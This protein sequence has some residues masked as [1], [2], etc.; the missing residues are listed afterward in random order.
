MVGKK[1]ENLGFSLLEVVVAAAII[2]V[3]LGA[4]I[5]AFSNSLSLEQ[6]NLRQTQAV[7]LAEEAIEVLRHLRDDDWGNISSPGEYSI[8]CDADCVLASPND[9]LIGGIFLQQVEIGPAYR[10]GNYRLADAGS[11]DSDTV[12]V[13]ISVSWADRGATST[14]MLQTYLTNIFSD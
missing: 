4:I 13:T 14:R 8:V 7:F 9:E 3:S 10:D 2:T 11:I 6:R 5:V 1:Y 12:K